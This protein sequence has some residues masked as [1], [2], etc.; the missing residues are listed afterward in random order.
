MLVH[1]GQRELPDGHGV[2]SESVRGEN[3]MF[4]GP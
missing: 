3:Q 1:V 2:T 4:D